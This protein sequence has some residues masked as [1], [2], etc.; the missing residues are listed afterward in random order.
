M[1]LPRAVIEA[2]ERADAL[3]AQ[4]NQQ[5]TPPA[6]APA[7]APQA[8]Q[9]QAPAEP[10]ATQEATPPAAPAAPAQTP[11][12]ESTWEQR[13]KVLDGKYRAEVPRLHSEIK[14]LKASVTT[15]QEQLAA[16]KQTPAPRAD[17]TAEEREQFGDELLN[18]VARVAA[19]QA[20]AAPAA[21]QVD[22]APV[23]DRMQKLERFV[24]ET[25][26]DGFFRK[27]GERVK[28]WEAQNTD[29]GFV[30]WL[31]EVDPLTGRVRQDLFNEAYDAL[32]VDRITAFFT[33]YPYQS[34]VART[35]SSVP[36]LDS[37]VAP[38]VSRASPPTPPGQKIWTRA[39]V[40]AYYN[41]VR[42]GVYAANPDEQA[43]IEQDIFAAQREKRIR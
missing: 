30:K 26:E 41:D 4:R 5:G 32:N 2:N 10:A 36:S 15:L 9:Q 8:P 31:S 43:R 38:D 40:Q 25:A 11:A 29:A 37:Q 19:A 21:A 22:L 39:E 16:A 33:A 35:E 20:P 3:I 42:R 27:L 28:H 12:F 13:F 18:V 14:D 34:P 17:F 24:A 1:A 7:A 6:A 23:T